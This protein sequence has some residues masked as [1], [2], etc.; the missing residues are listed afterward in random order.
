MQLEFDTG[1][2]L[3]DH[4]GICCCEVQALDLVR[5]AKNVSLDHPI[6]AFRKLSRS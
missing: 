1:D 2:R 3:G 6:K 5:D 4:L